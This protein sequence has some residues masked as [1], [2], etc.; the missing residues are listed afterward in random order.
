MTEQTPMDH[1]VALTGQVGALR[2]TIDRSEADRLEAQQVQQQTLRCLR[3]LEV[4]LDAMPDVEHADHHDFI[5]VL[6]AERHRRQ[7]LRDAVIHKLATGGAWSAAAALVWFLW[8]AL[9]HKTG[10]S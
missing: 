3:A 10:T 8:R 7:E 5:K 1:I 4:R 6:V 9:S 2:A